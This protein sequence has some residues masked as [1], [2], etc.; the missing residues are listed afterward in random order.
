MIDIRRELACAM[1]DLRLLR[2]R[3][4]EGYEIFK[5]A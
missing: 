3:A 2:A 1:D 5:I 4:L